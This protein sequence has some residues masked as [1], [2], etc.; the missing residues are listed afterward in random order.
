MKLSQ[1]FIEHHQRDKLLNKALKRRTTSADDWLI[2]YHYGYEKPHFSVHRYASDDTRSQS[3]FFSLQNDVLFLEC[4]ERITPADKHM[5]RDL[6][7]KT[8]NK[9][10]SL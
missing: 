10:V 2:T 5:A 1:A 4:A 7:E 6:L 3:A 8:L 9:E